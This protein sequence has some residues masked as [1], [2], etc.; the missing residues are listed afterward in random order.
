MLRRSAG[1]GPVRLD[2]A[3]FVV[4]ASPPSGCRT[5][6][7]VER[8]GIDLFRRNMGASP[9]FE[10]LSRSLS[11]FVLLKTFVSSLLLARRHAPKT[12][13][14]PTTANRLEHTIQPPYHTVCQSGETR[15][16]VLGS[17]DAPLK[18]ASLFSRRKQGLDNGRSHPLSLKSAHAF[19]RRSRR[20][21]DRVFELSGV[22]AR[23]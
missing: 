18:T 5:T 6:C 13:V 4:C 1:A 16:G 2:N 15:S 19:D 11:S 14:L 21:A 7:Q 10:A 8:F 20:R 22:S 9:L 3:A 23:F 12:S 17:F